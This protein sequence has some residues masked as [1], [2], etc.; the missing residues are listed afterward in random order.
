MKIY[1]RGSNN[2]RNLYRSIQ[3]SPYFTATDFFEYG[4]DLFTNQYSKDD[5]DKLLQ[6]LKA[7]ERTE[8]VYEVTCDLAYNGI[9]VSCEGQYTEDVLR[10]IMRTSKSF[11][12]DLRNSTLDDYYGDGNIAFDYL[13]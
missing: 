9:Y 3:K 10:D 5:I 4:N 6:F 11:G 13:L 8:Y 12:I 7:I 2:F 1:I